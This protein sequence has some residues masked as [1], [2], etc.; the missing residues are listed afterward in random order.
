[1]KKFISVLKIV[2]L[3]SLVLLTCSFPDITAA[4]YKPAKRTVKVITK[5]FI[6]LVLKEQENYT[7]FTVSL[8]SQIAANLK[9]PYEIIL[10]ETE[11]DIIEAL[12]TGKADIGF[13]GITITAGKEIEVDFSHSYFESG[14]QMLVYDDKESS[15]LGRQFVEN[16]SSIFTSPVLLKPVAVFIILLFFSANLVWFAE[17]RKNHSMFPEKYLAGIWESIWWS[18]VTITTVGYGDK[19]PRSSTGRV[20]ALIWMI[21][22]IFI[23]SFF[24][25]S[26][27]SSLTV[28]GLNDN[29]SSPYDL[30]GKQVCTVKS[31]KA[32]VFLK[33]I[34]A[35]V[36]EFESVDKVYECLNRRL[37]SAAV[38]DAPALQHFVN[39]N[40]KKQNRGS[41]NSS[42]SLK[43]KGPVFEKI[44]YGFAFPE[45]S[46]LREQVNQQIL[47][48]KEIGIYRKIY[49]R[50]FG[51]SKK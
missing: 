29:I 51:S 13:G 27:S 18:A 3:A 28:K 20:L 42:Y 35:R 8:W 37:V 32:A 41:K 5:E 10:A 25:A 45:K 49:S 9:Q 24:T 2:M 47:I 33:K 15:L 1:M 39:Q 26:I 4:E 16:I 12:K 50:W 40:Q 22:G 23:I 34:G 14:L 36:F 38:Y 31:S 6:P 48:T 43:L 19:T 46:S 30:A 44:D 11:Q 7:G 17:K 21:T